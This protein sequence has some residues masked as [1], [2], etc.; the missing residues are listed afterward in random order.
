MAYERPTNRSPLSK[1]GKL[2]LLKDYIQHYRD[3]AATDAKVLNR[4]VPRAAFS[5]LLDRLGR[6]LLTESKKLTET[7]GRAAHASRPFLS[8]T[9]ALVPHSL[10]R[11]RC[12]FFASQQR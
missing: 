3:L 10:R 2:D 6:M 9:M 1:A 8:P 4:K 12:V 11:P 7:A 5:D